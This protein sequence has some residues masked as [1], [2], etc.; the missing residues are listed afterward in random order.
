M[1]APA[2]FERLSELVLCS[3]QWEICLVYLD[4]VVVFGRTYEE[5]MARLDTVL[6][7]LSSAGLKL[8]PRMS[9]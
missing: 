6:T 1:N 5:H 7:R 8:K 4:D 9:E 2:S 3:L